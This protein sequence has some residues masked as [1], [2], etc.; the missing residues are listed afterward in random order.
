MNKDY[1]VKGTPLP[2]KNEDRISYRCN[3]WGKDTHNT[4]SCHWKFNYISFGSMFYDGKEW[5]LFEREHYPG[6]YLFMITVTDLL[7]LEK[8]HT[9]DGRFPFIL[10][11]EDS[12][13]I[14]DVACQSWKSKLARKWGE[15]MFINN[16][17]SITK[18]FYDEMRDACDSKQ[19]KVLDEIFGVD[20]EIDFSILNDTDVFYVKCKSGYEYLFKGKDAFTK[21]TT[22]TKIVTLKD[23]IRSENWLCENEDVKEFR[24]ATEKEIELFNQNFN[25][26][27]YKEGELIFVRDYDSGVWHLRYATGEIKDNEVAAYMSQEKSGNYATYKYHAPATGVKLPK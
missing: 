25:P 19:H 27:P 10:T 8:K 14:Y 7:Q 12:L 13:K 26:C 22:T 11:K 6:D 9:D 1:R 21:Y 16:C 23:N 3:Q 2:I 18:E 15:E 4:V 17:I 24:L 20:N 5:I